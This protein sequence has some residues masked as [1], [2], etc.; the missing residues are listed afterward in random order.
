MPARGLPTVLQ[1]ILHGA[2][3]TNTDFIFLQDTR[4]TVEQAA[5]FEYLCYPW[6]VF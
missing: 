4:V 6:A 3:L 2:S 1:T 5:W